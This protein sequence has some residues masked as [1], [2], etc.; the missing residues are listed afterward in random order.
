M[1]THSKE[2]VFCFSEMLNKEPNL[3]FRVVMRL[4]PTQIPESHKRRRPRA[5]GDPRPVDSR[6]RGND[7]AF[8]R[9]KRGILLGPCSGFQSGIP[10]FARNDESWHP[11]GEAEGDYF[12]ETSFD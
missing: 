12:H 11:A 7:M 8:A 6:F 3:S 1:P 10:R 2:W 9:A 4:L 5:S